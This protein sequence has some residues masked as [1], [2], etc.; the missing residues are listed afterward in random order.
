MKEKES[1]TEAAASSSGSDS[2]AKANGAVSGK[3]SRLNKSIDS[4]DASNGST[5]LQSSSSSTAITT[6]TTS[7]T[8]PPQ[9]KKIKTDAKKQEKAASSASKTNGVGVAS[10]TSANINPGIVPLL[11]ERLRKTRSMTK[12]IAESLD[13]SKSPEALFSVPS[14]EGN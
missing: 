14:W 11:K 10:E 3:K 9:S 12:E 4:G 6:T 1:A 5:T 7:P 2:Q 8:S 13:G